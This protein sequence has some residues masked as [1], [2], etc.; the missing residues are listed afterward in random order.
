MFCSH[1][2][3]NHR[4]PRSQHCN[5]V[6][7][8]ADS[9]HSIRQD[10]NDADAEVQTPQPHPK[11]ARTEVCH[12]STWGSILGNTH[13]R[14]C[15]TTAQHLEARTFG[16]HSTQ[17]LLG[18]AQQHRTAHALTVLLFRCLWPLSQETPAAAAAGSDLDDDDN[19][20]QITDD[21]AVTD[22][23]AE[24]AAEAHKAKMLSQLVKAANQA[25]YTSFMLVS[26][27]SHGCVLCMY[28]SAVLTALSVCC[29]QCCVR[30]VCVHCPLSAGCACL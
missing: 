20:I 14:C 30:C 19:A 24:L 3:H 15:Q 10:A 4:S 5:N 27:R 17:Q 7:Q 13:G 9:T 23:E 2:L 25:N 6:L 12:S 28:K 11:R 21:A 22:T 26:A 1:L 18:A 16:G 8:G 29:P